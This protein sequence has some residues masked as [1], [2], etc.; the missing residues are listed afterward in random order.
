MSKLQNFGQKKILLVGLAREGE[1]SLRF[2]RSL[3]PNLEIGLADQKQERE[4][5]PFLRKSLYQDNHLRFYLGKDF[6]VSPGDYNLIIRSP[7][8][9]L[10]LP[11]LQKA[12]EK[13]VEITSQTKIF[14]ENTPSKIIGVT[15]TKGKSTTSSL[16]YHVLKQNQLKVNLVGNIGYPVL[17]FFEGDMSLGQKD[18]F[19]VFELS[20]HQLADLD[21][22]PWIAVF[23]NLYSDHLDYFSDLEEYQKSKLNLIRHQTEKDYLVYNL[24]NHRLREAVCNNRAKKLPFSLVDTPEASC[25]ISH[26]WICYRD[27]QNG[28]E[29]KIIPVSEIPLVGKFNFQNVMPSIIISRQL[30]L[31]SISI[32]RAVKNFRS[33]EHRLTKVGIFKGITFYDDSNA[34]IPEATIE[35]LESLKPDV[36]TLILGGSEKN[37]DFDALAKKIIKTEVKTLILFPD[38]GPK[39]WTILLKQA[40][41]EKHHYKVPQHFLVQNMEKAVSL[42]YQWTRKGKICLLSPAS[43]SFGCFKDYKERGELFQTWVKKLALL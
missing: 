23:L 21:T 3:F 16:I 6:P 35:A 34:T 12:R 19:Y 26:G 2:L 30:G 15:G 42:A 24:D 5:S 41:E 27:H 36:D 29:E 43:A 9:P 25:F 10:H 13:G 38:T 11:L 32:R 28:Q 18:A 37:L 33:L 7:G 40:Q 17:S 20:S 1:S 4:L 14:I 8:I 39:I 31:P 22:S